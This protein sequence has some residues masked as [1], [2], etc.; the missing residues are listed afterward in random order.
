MSPLLALSQLHL[1]GVLPNLFTEVVIA[2]A[3]AAELPTGSP[4]RLRVELSHLGSMHV[5]VPSDNRRVE[6]LFHE[7]HGGESESLALAIEI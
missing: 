3:V 6:Q 1:L 7:L 5:R 2:P 4:R